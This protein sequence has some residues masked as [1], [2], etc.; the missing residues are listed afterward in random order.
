MENEIGFNSDLDV[1]KRKLHVQTSYDRDRSLARVTIFDG[2][3]LLSKREFR[4][5]ENPVEFSINDEITHYHELVKTDIEL[6]FLV[7]DKVKSSKHLP[8]INRLG[9]LFLERGLYNE[10][11]EQL[12]FARKIGKDGNV[13]EYELGLAYFKK[14]DYVSAAD[15]LIS[16]LENSPD[17][18]DIH[19]LLGKT[20]WHLENF[21]L[22]LKEIKKA[23]DLNKNYS[24][25][26]YTLGI[27]LLESTVDKP[28]H[29]DL[30]P[31]I[32]RIKDAESYLRKA[33]KNKDIYDIEFMEKGLEKLKEAGKIE[34]ALS[35]F[36]KAQIVKVVSTSRLFDSEFYIKFMFGQLDRDS[37]TLDYYIR[38]IENLLKNHPNYADLRQ[39][40]GIAYLI[41][42]WQC[43]GKATEEFKK[44]V[45]I[46]PSFEKASRKLKLMQNDGRGLLILLRAILN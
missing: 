36:E 38:N 32:E 12:L 14:A 22:A 24:E 45:E 11:I 34:E 19:L 25:A 4:V 29:P 44:A 28:M 26:L 8:S 1:S 16:A 2:G 40:L 27:L 41:K 21:A 18:P 43:F 15:L 10:A 30:P 42:G 7:A 3:T 9:S 35:N 6:L 5:E 31:P 37:K 17:Y 46:N 13:S 20:Y 33:M 23:T 39:S